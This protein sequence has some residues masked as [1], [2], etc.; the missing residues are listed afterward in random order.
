MYYW[1]LKHK[2]EC[3]NNLVYDLSPKI[4]IMTKVYHLNTIFLFK[5]YVTVVHKK[6]D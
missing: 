5:Q 3:T 1:F 4:Y 2:I 6:L